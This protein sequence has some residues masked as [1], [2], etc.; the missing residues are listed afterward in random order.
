MGVR[1]PSIYPSAL[2]GTDWGAADDK[3]LDTRYV[4]FW[5][6]FPV[7]VHIAFVRIL[8]LFCV[9]Q[10]APDRRTSRAENLA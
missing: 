1:S 7:P 3:E 2:L 5:V 9:P 4:A 8:S 10:I 6:G